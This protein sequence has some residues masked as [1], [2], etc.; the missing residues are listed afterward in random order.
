MVV[1]LAIYSSLNSDTIISITAEEAYH[2]VKYARL[3]VQMIT[4]FDIALSS[5]LLWLHTRRVDYYVDKVRFLS[6]L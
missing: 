5:L 3:A 4:T 1:S 2:R 6:C